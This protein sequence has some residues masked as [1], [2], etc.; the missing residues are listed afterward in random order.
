MKVSCIIVDDEPLAQD[1]LKSYIEEMP[2]LILVGV[3]GDAFE[4]MELLNQQEVN[5]MFL[6]INMPKISGMSFAKSLKKSPQI[7][8]V[9]AYPQYAVEGF[10]VEA[11]DYLLKPF[12]ADRFLLSVNKALTKLDRNNIAKTD[13]EQKHF[14][15]KA[16]K[17]LHRIPLGEIQYFQAIGDFV[18][19]FKDEG[20][21]ITSE[22]MKDIDEKLSDSG[23]IRIHKS[24][25]VPLNKIQFIEGNRAKVG[26]EMI[27][28]GLTYKEQLMEKFKG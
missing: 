14:V 13:T 18:K 28:V 27:P 21:L 20:V 10:E 23:F 4:A 22:K 12:S 15:V 7:I 11:V 16:D 17:K 2:N 3:C 1:V 6:D 5:I 24:Y 25:V 9:T 26:D 8:F 19:L